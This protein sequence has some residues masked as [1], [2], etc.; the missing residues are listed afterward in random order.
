LFEVVA[1]MDEQT[2][3]ARLREIENCG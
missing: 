3:F 1:D 2:A